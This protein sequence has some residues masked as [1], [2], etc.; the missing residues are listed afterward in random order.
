MIVRS[1]LCK[2]S[3]PPLR[4]F[5]SLK[6]VSLN[7]VISI[8]PDF[9]AKCLDGYLMK[10]FEIDVFWVYKCIIKYNRKSNQADEMLNRSMTLLKFG[11][12]FGNVFIHPYLKLLLPR[13]KLKNGDIDLRKV[14]FMK[15]IVIKYTLN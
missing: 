2:C 5:E 8:M 1:N 12:F 11:S 3:F 4:L 10:W 9:K 13:C 15:N 7:V 6:A 14:V